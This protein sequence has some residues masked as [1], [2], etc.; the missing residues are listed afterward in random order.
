MSG[1]LNAR[2]YLQAGRRRPR[3][4]TNSLPFLTQLRDKDIRWS[5]CVINI[6]VIFITQ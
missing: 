6:K 4:K 3:N 1:F 2:N 5:Y